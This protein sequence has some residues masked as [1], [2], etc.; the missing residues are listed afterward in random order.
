MTSTWSQTRAKQPPREDRVA[1]HRA[2][3]DAEVRAFRLREIR[4]EQGLTQ[5]APWVGH[6]NTIA[7]VRRML[8]DEGTHTG[9]GSVPAGPAAL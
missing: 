5:L 2:R 4:E 7:K 8:T 3:M 9:A 1:E 6:S